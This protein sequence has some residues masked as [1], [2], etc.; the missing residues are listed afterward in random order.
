[1]DGPL[2][3]PLSHPGPLTAASLPGRGEVRGFW[4]LPDGH[5][6]GVRGDTFSEGVPDQL[7]EPVGTLQTIRGR[8]TLEPRVD[9]IELRDG[10]AVYRYHF[11]SALFTVTGVAAT[12]EL[13]WHYTPGATKATML[14]IWRQAAT[15][16]QPLLLNTI[17]PVA[18]MPT[19]YTYQDATIQAGQ[20]YQ[21][22]I[23]AANEDGQESVPS[24][25]QEVAI[26]YALSPPQTLIAT[27]VEATSQGGVL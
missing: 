8:V 12:V 5:V 22:W 24:V 15:D 10:Q 4:H 9:G 1:M 17:M 11:T 21:Y 18:P 3:V 16:T 6:F 23:T 20:T 19:Q 27:Y 26:P 13:R 7:W 2:T 14:R 25:M